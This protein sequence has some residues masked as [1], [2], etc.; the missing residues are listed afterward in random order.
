MLIAA[1]RNSV[2]W[3]LSPF[4]GPSGP[5]GGTSR[6]GAVSTQAG[7]RKPLGEEGLGELAGWGWQNPKATGEGI[8]DRVGVVE[9]TC[10]SVTEGAGLADVLHVSVESRGRQGAQPRHHKVGGAGKR[11]DLG[12]VPTYPVLAVCPALVQLCGLVEL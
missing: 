12:A 4:L 2:P 1:P 9:E 7:N 3:A 6:W 5:R 11:L 8:W 10:C